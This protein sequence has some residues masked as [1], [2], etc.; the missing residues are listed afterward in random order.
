MRVTLVSPSRRDGDSTTT[1]AFRPNQDGSADADS[2]RG[3]GVEADEAAVSAVASSIDD[4]MGS[5]S[6]FEED[7]SV[8]R[9]SV[10]SKSVKDCTVVPGQQGTV[11]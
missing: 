9:S 11:F 7:A 1:S 8:I 6:K 4:L 3:G 10:S 5:C 2:F